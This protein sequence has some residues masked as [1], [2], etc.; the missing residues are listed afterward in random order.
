MS[1]Q[2]DQHEQAF[3]K[4]KAAAEALLPSL[5]DAQKAK[6]QDGTAGPRGTR[7]WRHAARGYADDRHGMGMM[8]GPM[9]GPR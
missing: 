9:G 4:V 6:A 2:M 1:D 7:P 8:M 3:G 5:D